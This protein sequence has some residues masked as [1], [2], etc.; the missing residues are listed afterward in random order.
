MNYTQIVDDFSSAFK[1]FQGY[2]PNSSLAIS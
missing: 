1:P 2:A